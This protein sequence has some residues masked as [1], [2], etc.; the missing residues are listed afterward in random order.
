LNSF[1]SDLDLLEERL[2]LLNSSVAYLT[3]RWIEMEMSL[4]ASSIDH[5]TKVAL[6]KEKAAFGEAIDRLCEL[7]KP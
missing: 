1:F 6:Q 7:I 2:R 3:K 5:N 4:D